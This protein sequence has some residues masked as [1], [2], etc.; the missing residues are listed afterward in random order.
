MITPT[1]VVTQDYLN[2][3]I[4]FNPDKRFLDVS[5][6]KTTD[7]SSIIQ[8]DLASYLLVTVGSTENNIYGITMFTTLHNRNRMSEVV[9]TTF[10]E[11]S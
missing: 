10:T 4:K 7:N 2:D 1:I 6:L 11:L 3:V 8:R 5:L 9:N